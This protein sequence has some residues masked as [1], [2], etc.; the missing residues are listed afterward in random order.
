MEMPQSKKN[1]VAVRNDFCSSRPLSPDSLTGGSLTGSAL[2]T[3]YRR[4]SARGT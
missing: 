3:L 2:L 4:T 1:F